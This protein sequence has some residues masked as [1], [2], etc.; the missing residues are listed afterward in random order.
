MSTPS[1]RASAPGSVS[2]RK[3]H[4]QVP[5]QHGAAPNR[6]ASRQP[7]LAQAAA[8]LNAT[9]TRLSTALA[10]AFLISVS[11]VA[12]AQTAPAVAPG[13]A[14]PLGITP[15][16]LRGGLP[17]LLQRGALPAAVIAPNASNTPLGVANPTRNLPSALPQG[18]TVVNGQASFAQQGNRLTVTNTP[19]TIINWQQFNVGAGNVTWFNQQ[20]AQSAVLNRVTGV[21]PSQILG[22]L[23]SNGRVF[24]VNPNGVVFG[25]GAMVDTA[26]LVVSTLDI[27][28]EDFKAGRLRFAGLPGA[29]SGEIK[30]DG[31][32]RAQNGDVYIIGGNVSNEGL[33]Q[34]PNGTVVL[35]A[36]QSV[37]LAGRGLEGIR[38]EVGAG[39]EARNL[40]RIEGSAVG[41]FAGSL[42]HSGAIEATTLQRV[43]GEVRLVAQD[44]TLA[45]GSSTRAT[46]ELGGGT[47]NVGGGL[48]GQDASIPNARNTTV[49]AGAVV[50]VSATGRGNGG[51]AVIYATDLATIHGDLIARGGAQGG[52]GGFIETS[53]KKNLYM[54]GRVDAGAAR[55]RAGTW[56]IDPAE[57][58]I[59][60]NAFGCYGG[61]NII[62]ENT[63]ESATANVLI[64]ADYGVR[65]SGAFFNNDIR[66][67]S[68]LDF[69][70]RTANAT[71]TSVYGGVDGINLLAY[72]GPVA[73][74]TSGTGRISLQTHTSGASTAGVSITT[75]LLSAGT[76]GLEIRSNGATI[77]ARSSGADWV[78]YGGLLVSGASRILTGE[79]NSWSAQGD[80][81][82][83][84]GAF[85]GLTRIDV[86]QQLNNPANGGSLSL[87]SSSGS[88]SLEA[89][90]YARGQAG[91]TDEAGGHGGALSLQAFSGSVNLVRGSINLQ[92][93][94]G[95]T[96]SAGNNGTISFVAFPAPESAPTNGAQGQ[97]GGLGGNLS[98][99]ARDA[100]IANVFNI[101]ASGGNG[102]TGGQG[103]NVNPL[104]VS[105]LTPG[106]G[107]NGGAG[108]TGGFVS[109]STSGN[110]TL[111]GSIRADGGAGGA[112]GAAG[113]LR[114]GAPGTNP[115]AVRTGSGGTGGSFSASLGSVST[116]G[117]TGSILVEGGA[118]ES[119]FGGGGGGIN[120]S[121]FTGTAFTVLQGGTLSARGG[122]V[123]Q[124]A[125][126][127]GT[128][129]GGGGFITVTA[130]DIRIDGTLDAS[131]GGQTDPVLRTTVY[132]SLRGGG[133]SIDLS[134][135]GGRVGGP[136][137]TG[138]LLGG[139]SILRVQGSSDLST[140]SDSSPGASFLG[141]VSLRAGAAGV[142]QQTGATLV[143]PQLNLDSAGSVSLASAANALGVVR[144]TVLG[145][146]DLAASGFVWFDGDRR[147]V[148]GWQNFYGGSNLDATGAVRVAAAPGTGIDIGEAVLGD[149]ITLR[150]DRFG[151]SSQQSI[152]LDARGATGLIDIGTSDSAFSTDPLR[153][154]GA[155]YAPTVR[156]T[157]SSD[158]S[159]YGGAEDA[160]TGMILHADEWSRMRG[161][162]LRLS[163]SNVVVA[164]PATVSL[165][166]TP[167]STLAL[168]A[169][170]GSITQSAALDLGAGQLQARSNGG[171]VLLQNA[172]NRAGSVILAGE[173]VRYTNTTQPNLSASI[174][175]ANVDANVTTGGAL[176][177]DGTLTGALTAQSS[178]ALTFG[179]LSAGSLQAVS[180][181]AA[182]AQQ[183]AT[184]LS[185]TGS[186]Q[187]NA[188]TAAITLA[189]ATNDF[190]GLVS[191]TGGNV[192][193]RDANALSAA[194]SAA[195]A[196][197]TS[198]GSLAVSG[199]TSAGLTTTA[200]ATSF[201]ATT[202]GGALNT[203]ASGA[204][205]QTGA[206]T[207]NGVTTLNAA[208][209]AVT[210]T[211][212]ANN[213]VGAVSVTGG[214]VQLADANA[215]SATLN[216]ASA[217]LTAGGALTVTGSTTGSFASSSAA[218]SFGTLNVGT[219]LGSTATGA[220]TQTGALSVGGTANV[221]AGANN[222]TL[223]NAAN[224][225]AGATTLTGGTVQVTDAN[226]L[227]AVINAANATVNA[228]GALSLAGAVS[229][230][231]AA[232]AAGPLTQTAA[233]SVGGT[234]VLNAGSN[235]ITLANAG[236]DFGGT[237]T[238]T[239]GAVQ[240]TDANAL[241]VNLTAA[242]GTLNAGGALGVTGSTSGALNTSSAGLSLGATTVG[243]DLNVVSSGAVTQTGALTVNG[244]TT[245][246]AG[247]NAVTLS[248]AANN[249]VGAV[250]ATGGAVQIADVNAL[251]V[252]LSAASATLS[253]GGALAVSGS[254][255]GALSTSSAGLILDATTVGTDLTVSSTGAVTQTGAI[256]VTGNTTVSAGTNAVTL[257]NAANDFVG[258]VSASGSNVDLADAND[259]RVA[260]TAADRVGLNAGGSITQSAAVT[261]QRV[262]ATAGGSIDLS[263]ADN[264]LGSLGGNAG[265]GV[266]ARSTGAFT[267]GALDAAGNLVT[268]RG[269]SLDLASTGDVLVLGGTQARTGAARIESSAGSLTLRGNG[270][271]I[272]AAGAMDLRADGA[273]VIG[274]ASGTGAL[275][276]S[277]S[278]INAIATRGALSVGNSAGAFATSV[279]STAGAISLRAGTTIDVLGGNAAGASTRI[280]A[281]GTAGNPASVSL[282]AG[283]GI[284][285]SA[286]SG[287]N[288]IASIT[289]VNGA[290]VTKQPGDQPDIAATAP[291]ADGSSVSLTTTAGDI[292]ILA[293]T[294]TDAFA[295]VGSLN[296]NSTQLIADG[297]SVRLSGQGNGSYAAAL[298]QTVTVRVGAAGSLQLSPG[299]G[300]NAD[301]VI[302]SVN[303]PVLPAG[304]R[305]GQA[306]TDSLTNGRTDAG[307]A[308][309]NR[310]PL[311]P[312]VIQNLLV[313]LGQGGSPFLP[314][315]FGTNLP[316]NAPTETYDVCPK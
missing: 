189:N 36:G 201:G 11:G 288:A 111:D 287:A 202:V 57:M 84:R 144:G 172:A 116:I 223:A 4:R 70:I 140:V 72:G 34:A 219:T 92:G 83:E 149:S 272:S 106:A 62:C 256:R 305:G 227:A 102:G 248:N 87:S 28:N 93:G 170:G 310:P 276:V 126:A 229:G 51:T 118:S 110:F 97:A 199:S 96:G 127:S 19:G 216:A 269:A 23:G 176:N 259:L 192:Q 99:G 15:D 274:D 146:L 181:G 43:G 115:N 240:I 157:L 167:F 215:L 204:V 150:A 186:T 254:T 69:T 12:L 132:N 299:T 6:S 73:I 177:I 48:R 66:L 291:N 22:T 258:A 148:L 234:S 314:T 253:A 67:P 25:Q 122:A 230:N 64:E 107:G 255:S 294:G 283:S 90:V 81:K 46:G 293:G 147:M 246:N 271:A 196:T 156:A 35:A 82:I 307:I 86:G 2:V 182:I 173:R 125:T 233:L 7:N 61:V 124:G 267:V 49:E 285:V 178:G 308:T 16:A 237:V 222:I 71:T 56:L 236:N 275:T 1:G 54:T 155:S 278:S 312:S 119:G 139:T 5:A 79:S 169:V 68:N 47:V 154:F 3:T 42:R 40:G 270:N 141:Q 166:S 265:G 168:T 300:T 161:E 103:G 109:V 251:N 238:A 187:L 117:S 180:G 217:S 162:T 39:G 304:F 151:A 207:V 175:R 244:A 77:D 205:T 200:G 297:G 105:A 163:G 95:G 108:G 185:V 315:G 101:N 239:G 198:A 63:I 129:A 137:A 145:N 191:A 301:A 309:L 247:G 268:L 142:T 80:I 242:S 128:Q 26:G 8:A 44:I 218:L 211:N 33:I 264:R 27:S 208:A 183:A 292:A 195:A 209:N 152:I 302:V 165:G 179:N 59:Q 282:L 91:A 296:S 37:E 158:T 143:T 235:A 18:A 113:N 286:G 174:E 262:I 188:G 50:D 134:Y 100:S 164:G 206:L 29:P 228:G 24:L 281:V 10:G 252:S 160:T 45:S 135:Y 277:A 257:S 266:L 226:A 85:S 75:G 14:L 32:M 232:T 284:T 171:D 245:L 194:L 263:R 249:F 313:S 203:T 298:G 114:S 290:S 58:T 231:L 78:S 94:D 220:V 306:P 133:G 88:I 243:T 225:F 303:R 221:N 21:D 121:S 131:G 98:I 261:A 295:Q 104:A 197:L 13:R 60:G 38:F 153:A 260:I 112:A 30:V 89:D 31:V 273:L 279:S 241:N 123:G 65:T 138:I 17:A 193:L 55:G 53:G 74:Y 210:L 289:A 52:N 130:D 76:G 311:D 280:N 316:G 120:I 41:V 184:T 213:F 214:A 159:V 190:G 250:S 136:P 212:A 224:N 20:N 9:P